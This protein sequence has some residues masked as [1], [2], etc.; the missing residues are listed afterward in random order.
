MYTIYPETKT[1]SIKPE[2]NLAIKKSITE[3]V[4]HSLESQGFNML[5]K[6][7]DKELQYVEA[8]FNNKQLMKIDNVT[9]PLVANIA[10][11]EFNNLNTKLKEFTSKMTNIKTPGLFTL[12]DSL[13]QDINNAN[14]EEL[15]Q[16]TVNAK[17]TLMAKVKSW[18]IP[19]ARNES[20]NEQFKM[21]YKDLTTAG[22]GLE[23][24]LGDIEKQLLVKKTEQ[25]NNI[26]SLETSFQLYYD[27]F[28]ELRKEFA[29]IV[30]IEET[31]KQNLEQFK[32]ENN[33]G[34]QEV[35]INKQLKEYE[36]ILKDIEN[37]RLLIHGSLIKLPITVSQN[38]NL[39]SVCKNLLK[40][41]DNTLMGSF[42]TIRSNLIG[43][44]VSLN[45]Q[46]AMLGTES[47]KTLD[48][49]LAKLSQKVNE[50]LLIKAEVF[51]SESRLKDAETIK[52][53]VDS[54]KGL[55]D[56]LLDAKNQSQ[57][58]IDQA[59]QILN[60]ASTDLV[61]ILQSEIS[62]NTNLVRS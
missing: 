14:L 33:V 62:S 57:T 52:D 26:R 46:Q 32:L 51:A 59:T 23:V 19:S 31:Y 44:G 40:E 4:V 27:A 54:L 20:L 56:R 39:I 11:S 24:K 49:N 8:V 60:E 34:L 45:A 30:A 41:I 38:S 58:N 7:S 16:K 47:A 2:T 50:D 42:P 9:Y 36:E 53:M 43:L 37:K 5:M 13:S 21:I 3:V 22:K 18:F 29:L 1:S 55:N 48:R 61:Y 17:P 35:N 25:E 15:W 12:I 10:K 6:P 28:Q